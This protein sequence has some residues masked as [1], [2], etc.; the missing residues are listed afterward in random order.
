MV[1]ILDGGM[2]GELITRDV[3]PRGELW[4]A[5]ALLDAPDKVAE[6]HR[7]Y[8]DAGAQMILTNTYSTVPSYLDKL[9]LADRFVELATLAGEIARQVA[10]EAQLPIQVAGSIPPLDESYRPDL[11]PDTAVARPIYLQLA[12]VLDP[13]VDLFV[14]ETMSCISETVN[15]LS[16]VRRVNSSKPVF[17]SWTLNETPG[18]GLRSQETIDAAVR[19]VEPFDVDGYLFNCTSPEAITAGLQRLV[20]LID[21]DVAIGAYPNRLRIPQG[22]TLD[23]EVPTGYRHD[24]DIDTY[25]AFAREWQSLGATVIGGC[26]GIGPDFIRALAHAL[27]SSQSYDGPTGDG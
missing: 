15:A 26:C 16:S 17:V 27:S 2:G 23:N 19:A 20:S 6:V 22:W 21:R 3:I 5:Q 13:F 7:D 18:Y 1:T 11:A 9:D 24:L 14:C 25:V 12:R 4:S 8:I 10:D